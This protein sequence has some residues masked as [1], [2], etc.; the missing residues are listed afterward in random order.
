MEKGQAG[1]FFFFFSIPVAGPVH[2]GLSLLLR[3]EPSREEV[4]SGRHEPLISIQRC[5]SIVF[6]AWT[7]GPLPSSLT[8][9]SGHGRWSPPARD[10]ARPYKR[11]PETPPRNLGFP[12]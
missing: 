11:Q 1:G 12:S 7:G 6:P 3:L 2:L 9:E 8:R 5:P 10:G 4:S